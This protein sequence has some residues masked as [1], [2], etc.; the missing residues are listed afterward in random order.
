M[1]AHHLGKKLKRINWEYKPFEEKTCQ[2]LVTVKR[3]HYAEAKELFNSIVQ[4][5]GWSF[6]SKQS[7][8]KNKQVQRAGDMV[9]KQDRKSAGS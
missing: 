2:V 7:D 8:S 5:N 4:Q 6:K 3:K 9:R 1:A